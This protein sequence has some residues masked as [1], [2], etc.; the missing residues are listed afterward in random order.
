M[1]IS[2]VQNLRNKGY[3]KLHASFRDGTFYDSV[4]KA[5]LTNNGGAAIRKTENGMGLYLP[6]DNNSW[7]NCGTTVWNPLD[8]VFSAAIWVKQRKQSTNACMMGQVTGVPSGWMFYQTLANNVGFFVYNYAADFILAGTSLPQGI[9]THLCGV[10][11]ATETRI[12]LNGIIK[13][14]QIKGAGAYVHPAVNGLWLG[15]YSVA[16]DGT[17]DFYFDGWLDEAFM[18]GG[19]A[20][21]DVEVARLCHETRPPGR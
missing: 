21:S 8:G 3:E 16:D 20:L 17:P 1:A 5:N 18:Y 13:G 15:A 7:M 19:Y 11:S 6:S 9:W 12:Y 10:S 4:R 14:T 2:V